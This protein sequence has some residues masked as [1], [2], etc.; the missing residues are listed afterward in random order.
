M[1]RMFKL[2]THL[3]AQSCV[4]ALLAGSLWAAAPDIERAR[5][6]YQRTDYAGAL[7]LLAPL[8]PKTAEVHALMGLCYYMQG[9]AKKAAEQFQKAVDLDPG[10]SDYHLWLGRALGRRA[11]TATF[12]SAPM[13]AIKAR[14]Q[15]ERAVELNPRN[16]EA[17]SDL[18]EFCLQAPGLLGG[19]LDKAE[20]LAKRMGEINPA[21]YHWAQA[22]LAEKRKQYQ[23]AEQQFRQAAAL[24]PNQ[25]GRLIDLAKFL[26]KTGRFD[27]SERT[28]RQAETL[29]PAAPRLLFERAS[30]YILA[31]RN[32]DAARDLLQKYLQSP[33][34]PDDPPRD[35]ALHLLRSASAG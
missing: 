16:L 2:K 14:E 19:G 32:L 28:I 21:E 12:I 20:T 25:V 7:R 24:S 4:L 10:V 5:A 15:F 8:E 3:F 27:E 22:R 29:A 30:I 18:F 9:E 23:I 11:E 33:L 6:S 1:M 35:Q 31:G 26:A 13:L 34:T 17:I